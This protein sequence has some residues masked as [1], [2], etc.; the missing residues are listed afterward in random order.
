MAQNL[1]NV[2]KRMSSIKTAEKITKT[3]KLISMSKVQRYLKEQH[4]VLRYAHELNKWEQQPVMS[5]EPATVICFGPDLGLVSL[6]SK[7]LLATLK[8][9]GITQL[10][11]L[12][13]HGLERV[14]KE[15]VW[16]VINK[17]QSS[18]RLNLPELLAMI[19]TQLKKANLFVAHAELISQLEIKF[20]I[21]PLNYELVFQEQ[22]LYEPSFSV[23]NQAFKDQI[24][25][26]R[27]YENWLNNKIIEHRLRQISM[28]KAQKSADDMLD[29][30]TN[31]YNRIRQANITQEISEIIGG[32][33]MEL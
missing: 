33:E 3:M 28:D 1:T 31:V 2:K 17:P 6:Y 5:N 13:N 26:S 25:L 11:W 7:T 14:L 19:P 32:R 29:Q 22:K 8:Q 20:T 18:E 21:Q 27:L 30:L 4:R 16:E 9:A 24:L 23:V 10:I 12:G 15:D